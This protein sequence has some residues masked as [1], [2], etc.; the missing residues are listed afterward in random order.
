MKQ[1][2]IGQTSKVEIDKLKIESTNL[3]LIGS[4]SHN[5]RKGFIMMDAYCGST[6]SH[7]AADAIQNHD[8]W[9]KHTFSN[10]KNYIKRQTDN[11]FTFFVFDNHKEFFSWLAE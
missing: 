4:I 7:I 1:I 6:F 8:T 11:G 5:K 2:I 9:D 10:L 3:P